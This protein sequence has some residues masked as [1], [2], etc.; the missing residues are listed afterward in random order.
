MACRVGPWGVPEAVPELSGE[1]RIIAKATRIG[2]RTDRLARVQEGAAL[3]KARG[4]IQTH[5]ID[6]MGIRQ[7]THRKQLL[8][9]AA[10]NPGF[11]C[12]LARANVWLSE[13]IFYD[14]ADTPEELVTARESSSVRR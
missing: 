14:V 5:G 9:V 13:A 8:K 12:H 11:G 2:D 3:Q 7:V 1:I 4:V 10:R 6:E